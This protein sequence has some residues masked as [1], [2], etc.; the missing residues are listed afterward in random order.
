MKKYLLTILFIFILIPFAFSDTVETFKEYG[1][2]EEVNA[3]NL[4][5]NFNNIR[6]VVN[7]SLNNINTK[8][9]FE[10]VEILSSLPIAGNQGR[11]VY[12]TTN[13]TINADNGTAWVTA[14]TYA[15][16]AVQGEM[17]YFN[18]TTWV[19]LG[20]GTAGNTLKS[21]G[22]A[23][24]LSWA[25]L[26]LAGGAGYITGTLPTGSGGTGATANA[27]AAN[28]VVVLDASGDVP[29]N[30]VNAAAIETGAVGTD[31]IS[32]SFMA[33]FSKVVAQQTNTTLIDG[34]LTNKWVIF[35]GYIYAGSSEAD[36]DAH[37]P[38]GSSDAATLGETWRVA[39]EDTTPVEGF[40][41]VGDADLKEDDI[42]T[43]YGRFYS[44]S[45][46][47]APAVEENWA[48]DVPKGLC[49]L[50]GDAVNSFSKDCFLYVD[51]TTFDLMLH[52]GTVANAFVA[53]SIFITVLPDTTPL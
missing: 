32:T 48:P 39:G 3:I 45:G 18:G 33:C 11:I 24:N 34:T 1:T 7:G 4:N 15:G 27:N 22:M 29:A 20:V 23:A 38:G 46:I 17:L 37:I 35:Q 10:F 49:V 47:A 21:G 53:F 51:A 14:P 13:D 16:D 12:N 9:G 5:G 44:E 52:V 50:N 36:C 26:N 41:G 40:A 43:F 2:F 31:E 42:S 19:R 6:N 25:A 30:S 8:T 28:G